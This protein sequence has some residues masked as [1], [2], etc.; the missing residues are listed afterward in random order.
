MSYCF[1]ATHEQTLLRES[2]HAFAKAE[3]EPRA[4]ALDEKGEFSVELTRKMAQQGYLGAM[5]GPDYGGLGLDYLSYIMLVETLAGFDSS[6]AATVAAHNSLGVAPI[7]YY[8]TQAQKKRFLP[9]LCTGEGGLWAF[10]QTEPD[11][12]SDVQ[13]I[14]TKGVFDGRKREWVINGS[15]QFITNGSS[16]MTH[17]ITVLAV[18]GEKAEGRKEFTTF[19][20]NA[21]A[22]GLEPRAMHRKGVWRSSDTAELY[23]DNVRVPEDHVLGERGQ[24]FKIMMSTLDRGRLSIAAM[25]L[26][27]SKRALEL[28]LGYAKLRWTF[29]KPIAE[30]QAI[31]FKLAEMSARIDATEL[32]LYKACWLCQNNMPFEKEAAEAKFMCSR[33]A[34]HCTREGTQIFGGSGLMEE[35]LIWRMFRDAQLLRIGEGT[36]EMQLLVIARRL[37]CYERD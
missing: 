12:G 5:V 18:T 31:A 4:F 1:N 22:K 15:K 29:G 17:G 9:A 26:G 30:H 27:I 11:A 32:L 21:D 13:S 7:Y 14:K 2:V 20:V 10:G 33:L 35:S 19:L 6:Q 28:A 25:G 37:G 36:D 24:G 34:E 3:I 23:L 16:P 8:G